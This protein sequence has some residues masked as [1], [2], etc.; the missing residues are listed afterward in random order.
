MTPFRQ[1]ITGVVEDK[2]IKT[3]K[4]PLPNKYQRLPQ[5]VWM[6][7][8][9]LLDER[10]CH[11]LCWL[12]D[13]K[14]KRV[15]MGETH[16]SLRG[17]ARENRYVPRWKSMNQWCQGYKVCVRDTS[18]VKGILGDGTRTHGYANSAYRCT[19]LFIAR[20]KAPKSR[21]IDDFEE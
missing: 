7:R 10:Y 6:K 2:K 13:A 20:G 16:P 4:R 1:N 15:K 11:S 19:T 3:N 18:P 21:C 8:V 5:V 14:N 17:N 9:N 12:R